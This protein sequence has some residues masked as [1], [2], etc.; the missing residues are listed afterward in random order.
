MSARR[1]ILFLR[2]EDDMSAWIDC[3]LVML[4]DRINGPLEVDVH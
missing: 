4:V 1:F 2:P 3:S